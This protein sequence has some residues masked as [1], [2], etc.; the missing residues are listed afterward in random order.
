MF[1]HWQKVKHNAIPIFY[2]WKIFRQHF[3]KGN[4]VLHSQIVKKIG[5]TVLDLIN[6]KNGNGNGTYSR[7]SMCKAKRLNKNNNRAGFLNYYYYRTTLLHKIEKVLGKENFKVTSL[8]C[9][10]G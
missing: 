1:V 2:H 10:W 6:N 3:G 9:W 7:F 8:Q 4:S 5:S